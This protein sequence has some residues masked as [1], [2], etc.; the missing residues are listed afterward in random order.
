MTIFYSDFQLNNTQCTA[1]N[2]KF[3]LEVVIS[4]RAFLSVH[5]LSFTK[6]TEKQIMKQKIVH[7][8]FAQLYQH[9]AII[10]VA[11]VKRAREEKKM[12]ITGIPRIIS[13]NQEQARS[14]IPHKYSQ[15]S[16]T[17]ITI[18]RIPGVGPCC[19]PVNVTHCGFIHR[20]Q[21]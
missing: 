2:F 19:L 8:K 12:Q 15:L 10:S 20:L 1:R 3:S 6:R 16:L 17:D 13:P 4:L 7:H 5:Q 14:L 21:R 9:H 18:R 11:M